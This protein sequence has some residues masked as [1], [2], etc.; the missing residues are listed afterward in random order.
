MNVLI[1][2]LMLLSAIQADAAQLSYELGAIQADAAQ[3]MQPVAG[4]GALD[5]NDPM[6]TLADEKADESERK[7]RII[8]DHL[9]DVEQKRY[10]VAAKLKGIEQIV[11]SDESRH[12][13]LKTKGLLTDDRNAK[14]YL[15]DADK[16]VQ[17]K[18]EL[19]IEKRARFAAEVI[20]QNH[21]M[22]R[23][24]ALVVKKNEQTNVVN[25][26]WL[27]QNNTRANLVDL[28]AKEAKLASGVAQ[29]QLSRLN[30]INEKLG[31]DK[32]GIAGL[33]G[34]LTLERAQETTLT[35]QLAKIVHNGDEV[36][37]IQATLS[38]KT[39][40]L[41]LARKQLETAK[42]Q[43]AQAKID[44]GQIGFLQKKTRSSESEEQI[45]KKK[46]HGEKLP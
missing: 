30:D 28:Q 39:A 14:R 2:S 8:E 21:L 5:L 40:K 6:Q 45:S 20:Q 19:K 33:T 42:A 31:L 44:C 41:E 23:N 11:K 32:R 12:N 1:A 18:I 24:E 13:I 43:A 9:H 10:V 3:L 7:Q 34:T 27:D 36:T 37:E 16:V 15:H 17:G 4:A 25:A 22:K 35:S 46:M 29:S 38:S 26:K